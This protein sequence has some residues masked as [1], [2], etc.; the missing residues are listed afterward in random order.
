[1]LRTD[2]PSKTQGVVRPAGKDILAG[3]NMAKM[4]ITNLEEVVKKAVE[5]VVATKCVE[6]EAEQI[7]ISTT[8]LLCE[9][10]HS[11]NGSELHQRLR[12]QQEEVGFFFPPLVEAILEWEK[13]GRNEVVSGIRELAGE[14]REYERTA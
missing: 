14:T 6:T 10:L 1:L 4:I 13:D 8:A 12:K 2:T 3:D 11:K 5:R 7:L 9:F